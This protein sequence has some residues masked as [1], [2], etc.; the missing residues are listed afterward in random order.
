MNVV[1]IIVIKID[2]KTIRKPNNNR[3][4]NNPLEQSPDIHYGTVI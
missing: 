2:I 4:L 1:H 3:R